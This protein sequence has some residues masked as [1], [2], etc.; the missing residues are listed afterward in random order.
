M[1][2]INKYG[3]NLESLEQKVLYRALKNQVRLEGVDETNI[4]VHHRA[5]LSVFSSHILADKSEQ[6]EKV[7][8]WIDNVPIKFTTYK[9]GKRGYLH[10]YVYSEKINN[11]YWMN[12]YLPVDGV[13]D[14]KIFYTRRKEER[15]NIKLKKLIRNINFI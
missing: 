15:R 10:Y 7:I 2:K 12:L 3:F 14:G 4:N 9:G 11:I 1:N 6:F 8:I 13:L 5:S